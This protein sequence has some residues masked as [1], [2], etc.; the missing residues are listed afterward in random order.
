MRE[1]FNQSENSM[2]RI[3]D[4]APAF[5]AVTTQ[6]AIYFPADYFGKWVILFSYPSDFT[7]LS[8]SEF[9]ALATMQFELKALNFELI[10]LQIDEQTS[11]N[12]KIKHKS[13]KN[14]EIK[15]PLIENITKEVARKYGMIQPDKCNASAVHSVF[16][17][18][19]ECNIRAIRYYPQSIWLNVDEL[20]RAIAVFQAEDNAISRPAK[21]YEIDKE[22][23][24]TKMEVRK[25][26]E[27]SF[28]I[29]ELHEEKVV[30]IN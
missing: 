28:Y 21:S 15:F 14:V 26:Y 9:K 23:Q 3:G 10:G 13:L 27:W 8:A 19:P 6:G 20:K 5:R 29:N 2:P 4:Q 12:G 11:I 7:A 25:C 30:N 16:F 17:I 24:D 22:Q 1:F 18:D